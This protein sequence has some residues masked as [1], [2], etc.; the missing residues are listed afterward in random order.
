MTVDDE[1][2]RAGVGLDDVF[3]FRVSVFEARRFVLDDGLVEDF[4]EVASFDFLFSGGGD[5]GGELEKFG[6]VFA[7]GAGSQENRGERE[8]VQ[9]IFEVVEDFV[10][11]FD[12]VG[13]GEDDDNSLAGFDDFASERLVEFAVGF[14]GVDEEGANVGL[15]NGGEGADGGEFFDADF[16]FARFSETGSVKDFESL[17][18]EL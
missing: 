17:A 1:P 4:V 7:G 2:R 6:D 18:F 15:F 10:G 14:G 12:K 5:F 9:V 11:V 8:E 16:A 13:F 3:R